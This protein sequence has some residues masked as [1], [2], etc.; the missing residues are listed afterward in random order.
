MFKLL[1]VVI[2]ISIL[3]W[4]GVTL[5]YKLKKNQQEMNIN[6][7]IHQYENNNYVIINAVIS[8]NKFLKDGKIAIKKIMDL[9]K[10]RMKGIFDLRE[11]NSFTRS[12][13]KKRAE[14]TWVKNNYERD[15]QSLSDHFTFINNESKPIVTTNALQS[16]PITFLTACCEEFQ[17][18]A[19]KTDDAHKNEVLGKYVIKQG[20]LNQDCISSILFWY[21]HTDETN[22][23][24]DALT[25]YIEAMSHCLLNQIFKQLVPPLPP[26]KEFL[27]ELERQKAKKIKKEMLLP[28]ISFMAE[29]ATY[30]CERRY[31][32]MKSIPPPSPNL[33]EISA[34]SPECRCLEDYVYLFRLPKYRRMIFNHLFLMYKLFQLECRKQ[35]ININI[36]FISLFHP[37]LTT[38]DEN[39]NNN[40]HS[41]PKDQ[42][43]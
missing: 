26:S 40:S 29:N 10:N 16:K 33:P 17:H 41:Q 7:G 9:L 36:D 30:T 43:S 8:K 18:C 2:V 35:T 5:I 42:T 13:N 25:N 37:Y 32:H 22:M 14:L 31:S 34:N 12:P 3:I 15:I 19:A 20:F 38:I 1:V 4:I 28:E 27:E 11:V 24:N 39:T 21:T 6:G 23:I